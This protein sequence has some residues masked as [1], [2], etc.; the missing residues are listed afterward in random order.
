M[1]VGLREVGRRVGVVGGGGGGRE[2]RTVR[3]A[4][5]KAG[6]RIDRQLISGN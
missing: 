3:T 2:E 6:R 1:C 4:R 5:R